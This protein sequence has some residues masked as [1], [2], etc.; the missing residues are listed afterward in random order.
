MIEF[1]NV[2]K[3]FSGNCV[4]KDISVKIN[5]GEIV[6]LIGPSG[7]GKTTTLKMINRLIKPSSGE[8]FIKGVDIS[9]QDVIALRRNLGYIIQQTGLFPHM[10]IQENI[11]I[12][13]RLNNK[14]E[15]N[16]LQ[17]TCAL[18]ELVGLDPKIFLKRYPSELSGGQQQ[19][20]G[21]AR[22]FSIDPEIIL[23]DEPFS[24]LDPLTRASL[25]DE[26]INL[27]QKF[28]KTIVFVTHDMDE[29]IKISDRLCI[30]SKGEIVQYDTPENILKNPINDYVT[31]FVGVNRIW[32]NAEYIK[33]E[34]FMKQDLV[35]CTPNLGIVK[36][37][38]IMRKN[39]LDSM[40]VIE[41]HTRK[42]L[43]IVT[44]KQLPLSFGKNLLVEE[45]MNREFPTVC[46]NTSIV[47]VLK[48][49]DKYQVETI[50]VVDADNILQ[51]LIT[52]NSLLATLS[53]QYLLTEVV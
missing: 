36:S 38:E 35:T 20:V 12:I 3:I 43:G 15:K 7:C 16:L 26:L 33:A 47:D 29:A 17:K 27:Q 9:K 18:M 40:P 31:E 41:V 21:F 14:D 10:N 6:T 11:E 44:A 48:I 5:K 46:K 28:K 8:I 30:M 50:P 32:L 23:M 39:G 4:L 24:A 52:K 19:R 37:L 2:S 13:A 25:Q 45:C 51:G 34:D 53:Q 49:V 22:A 1:R 42:L